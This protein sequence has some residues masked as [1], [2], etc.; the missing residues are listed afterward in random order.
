M[1]F[2]RQQDLQ[3]VLTQ[4]QYLVKTTENV[5]EVNRLIESPHQRRERTG[6]NDIVRRAFDSI[7]GI[8]V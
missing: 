6:L 8:I 7:N 4:A 2:M 3:T 1:M 5:H